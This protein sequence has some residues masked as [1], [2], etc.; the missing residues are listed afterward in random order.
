M[1]SS[2]S[3]SLLGFVVLTAC[4]GGTEPLADRLSGG[5]QWTLSAS[6]T[7]EGGLVNGALTCDETAGAI[8]PV[9]PEEAGHLAAARYRVDE[10]VHLCTIRYLLAGAFDPAGN[11]SECRSHLAHEVLVFKSQ[12]PNPD[13]DPVI[14]HRFEIEGTGELEERARIVSVDMEGGLPILDLEAGDYLYIAVRMTATSIEDF[15]CIGSCGTPV[16]PTSVA[17]WSNAREPPFDW[18]P[19]SDFGIEQ[20]Y[21][22]ALDVRARNS[23]RDTPCPGR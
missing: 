17:W 18:L 12:D 10:P 13:A 16:P 11:L 14:L 7:N 22:F 23:G 21:Q 6:S 5:D 1:R 4:G 15:L 8:H 20:Y 3:K 2:M 9:V 19:L